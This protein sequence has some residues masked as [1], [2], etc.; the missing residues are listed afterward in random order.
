MLRAL[1]LM[2]VAGLVLA[3]VP[4]SAAPPRAA[5]GAKPLFQLPFPCGTNWELDTWGHDPALDM[6]VEGNTGS[7][8]L[9]VL[10]SAAGTVSA[11]Y[12]NDGSGN[13]IQISHG[14]GWFTAYYHLKDDPDTYVKKGDAVQPSTRIG[15][16]GT[17]GASDWAHLHY[18]QRFLASGDFTDERHRVSAYFDGVAYTGAGKDWPSVTSRNCTGTPAAW[19]DCPS[20]SVRF[21]SGADGTGAVCRSA[22]DEPESRC[23]LRRSFFNNGTPQP[24]YDHVQVHFGEGG[25]ACLHYGWD[26]GR[27]NLPAGGRTIERFEWRGEC[28][29]PASLYRND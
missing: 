25:T 10:A 9:P 23:G 15:R 7:D 16:I 20:G 2:S 6:V 26:E 22:S 17:S 4:A 14:N 29:V 8:G 19:Q 13:T 11:T 21:Y 3:A 27:G 5:A 12:W 24:G 28:G 1:V 18:E